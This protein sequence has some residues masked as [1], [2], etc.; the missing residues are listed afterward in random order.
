M[1]GHATAVVHGGKMSCPAA[2]VEMVNSSQ[3]GDFLGG[4]VLRNPPASV[5]DAG[6]KSHGQRSL[7]GCSPWGRQESDRT[8]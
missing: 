8:E 2:G 6:E 4:S 3:T 5:G 7:V 1:E